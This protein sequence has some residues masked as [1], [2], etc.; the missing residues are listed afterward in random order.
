M[1]EKT[2]KRGRV[3]I[4]SS[5]DEI[6]G[7]CYYIYDIKDYKGKLFQTKHY[8]QAPPEPTSQEE[9]HTK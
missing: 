3:K 4:R 1:K 5:V 6:F 9:K 7:S 2:Y 8:Y